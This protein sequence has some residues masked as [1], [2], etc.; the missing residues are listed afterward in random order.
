M[1]ETLSYIKADYCGCCVSQKRALMSA[2]ITKNEFVT[3]RP[4]PC[5]LRAQV[6]YVTTNEREIWIIWTCTLASSHKYSF[7]TVV[8]GAVDDV[9][10]QV[11]VLSKF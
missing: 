2:M 8:F 10:I 3:L 6:V 9:F 5:L 1:L 4:H 7:F 11:D